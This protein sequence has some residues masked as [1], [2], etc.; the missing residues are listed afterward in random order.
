MNDIANLISNFSK[1]K[2]T[3][4]ILCFF[5]SFRGEFTEAMESTNTS[6]DGS[7]IKGIQQECTIY[8]A[9]NLTFLFYRRH[10]VVMDLGFTASLIMNNDRIIKWHKRFQHI[11]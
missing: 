5:K 3:A 4:V 2:V 1:L 9:V 7:A 10:V 6:I 11:D 8:K